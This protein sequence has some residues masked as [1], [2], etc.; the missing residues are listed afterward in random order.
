MDEEGS[1]NAALDLG[2]CLGAVCCQRQMDLGRWSWVLM[3]R[4]PQGKGLPCGVG[5]LCPFLPSHFDPGPTL[6]PITRL[7]E[8]QLFLLF[9]SSLVFSS[10]TMMGM[11]VDFFEFFCLWFAKLLESL[12]LCLLSNLGIFKPL[13]L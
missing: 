11:D 13:Q 12:G 5:W 4:E 7:T 1:Q 9:L 3:R 6:G 8:T 2:F 10:L